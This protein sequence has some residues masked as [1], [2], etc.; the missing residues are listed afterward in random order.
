MKRTEITVRRLG[1][2]EWRLWR[3]LRLEA[4]AESP[5]AF[6]SRLSDWQGRGDTEQRW[7]ARLADISYNVVAEV[8]GVP[9]GM[10]SGAPSLLP[11]QLELISL[12][13]APFARGKGVGDALLEAVIAWATV[14]GAP[15]LA[16][17]VVKANLPA[18]R[19]YLRHGFFCT[20]EVRDEDSGTDDLLMA[21]DFPVAEDP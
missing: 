11:E 21:L 6:G 18:V 14:C 3:E 12:W 5:H 20:A 7:R 13:V 8:S 10:V 15:R 2:D 17:R 4:L 19:L 9:A 1:V 16:L